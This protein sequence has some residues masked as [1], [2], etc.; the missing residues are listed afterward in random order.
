MSR[1]KSIKSDPHSLNLTAVSVVGLP[2][3]DFSLN[4]HVAL[5]AYCIDK[6]SEEK[7]LKFLLSLIHDTFMVKTL[8]LVCS[9]V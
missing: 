6:E 5:P 2:E 8:S 4:K 9:D 1:I 7:K 3:S